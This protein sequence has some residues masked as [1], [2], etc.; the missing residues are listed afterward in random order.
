MMVGMTARADWRTKGVEGPDGH[1][2]QAE[3]EVEG[4]RH[5]VRADFA[6]GIGGLAL[7]RMRLV[8]GHLARGAIDLAG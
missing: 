2:R 3:G 6:G 5:F 4:L 1:D 8:N 7:Q